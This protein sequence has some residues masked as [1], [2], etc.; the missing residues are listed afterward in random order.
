MTGFE[1]LD[2]GIKLT[3]FAYMAWQIRQT[4]KNFEKQC[5]NYSDCRETLP[6]RF[7]SKSETE[8]D[9]DELRSRTND[10]EK[11]ISHAEGKC[12]L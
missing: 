12:G 2:G 6:L 10:H 4:N 8:H 11:R 1:M 3:F 5:K 9:V 7:A